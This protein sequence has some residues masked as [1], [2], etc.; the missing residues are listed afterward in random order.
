MAVK[1]LCLKS[2]FNWVVKYR[3]NYQHIKSCTC[4][5][6][7]VLEDFQMGYENL[8]GNLDGLMSFIK[9]KL[10]FLPPQSRVLIMTMQSLTF[11]ADELFYRVYE[12]VSLI[13]KIIFRKFLRQFKSKTA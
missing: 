9:K 12:K 3:K 10:Y 6:M 4:W 2:V 13:S 5:G 11:Q 8:K 7:K 1:C